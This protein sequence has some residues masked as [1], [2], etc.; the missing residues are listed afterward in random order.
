MA[1]QK[2]NR[3]RLAYVAE[4]TWGTTPGTPTMLSVPYTE[5]NFSTQKGVF[6]DPSITSDRNVRFMRH[7]N[8]FVQGTVKSPLVDGT[9]DTW[10][11]GLLMS[12]WTTNV[13]KVGTTAKSFTLEQG[14]LDLAQYRVFTGCLPTSLK[15]S[16][17]LDGVITCEWG[18]IGQDDTIS[19]TPLDATVDSGVAAGIQPMVHIDG[20]FL[21]GGSSTGI[22]TSAEFTIDNKMAILHALGSDVGVDYSYGKAE[23]SGQ[24]TAYLESA[25]LINKYLNETLSSLT[26]TLGD[27]TN[28]LAF[29]FSSIKYGGAEVN[30]AGDGD[31][32]ITMPF[33]SIY[34]NTDASSI[35]ITRSA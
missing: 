10:L 28:T 18:W 23:I 29:D 17:P 31:V 9:F 30:V 4:S 15:V 34:D 12:T 26:L 20:T 8:Q 22:L 24:I 25:T 6:V 13:I 35:V 3:T 5:M 14:F 1:L 33:T 16:V 7:G 11:E 19:G 2:V 27:G 21:E 32:I